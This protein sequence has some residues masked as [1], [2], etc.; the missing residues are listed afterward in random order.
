MN[1]TY[2]VVGEQLD[3]VKALIAVSWPII[4][5]TGVMESSRHFHIVM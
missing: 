2:A 5:S 1:K 3:D 4:M